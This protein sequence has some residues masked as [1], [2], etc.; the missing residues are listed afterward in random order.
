MVDFGGEFFD[1]PL[2]SY[3]RV[4]GP[5]GPDLRDFP[6][7]SANPL[8]DNYVSLV[9]DL[10]GAGTN[11]TITFRFDG[12][13]DVD[14]LPNAD[15]TIARGAPFFL[16]N[17]DRSSPA[18]GQRVPVIWDFQ[19]LETAYQSSNLLT[20]APLHGVPLRHK[21]TYAAIVTT[22]VAQQN[23]LFSEVWRPDHPDHDTW[24]PVHEALLALGVSVGDV[25]VATVFTTQ[26]PMA[27]MGEWSWWIRNALPIPTWDQSL[28]AAEDNQF[29][30]AAEG[31]LEV[32]LWQ[33][34]DRPYWDEG[35]GFERSDDGTPSIYAWE[36]IAFTLAWPSSG[37]PPADG[38]P[39][40]IY[41][42]GTGGD[43]GTCCDD[44][45]GLEP[46]SMLAKAGFAT[47]GISQPLHGD[48][49]TSDTQVDFHT[50]NYLNPDAALSTFRQGGLDA[51]YQAHALTGRS[52]VFDLGG[53]AI[54]LDP[55]QV[56]FLGHSQGGITGALAAPFL[57]GLVDAVALS[58]AGGGL[59][60]TLVYRE[61][62]GLD[63]EELLRG[64]LALDA[65][66]E[67]DVLHPV[68]GLI[69]LLSEVT[70]PLNYARHWFLEDHLY[71]EG[72]VHVLM[73]EGLND[74]YTPPMT[75]EAMAAAGG[76]PILD[77]IAH[78]DDAH[79]L[80][81]PDSVPLPSGATTTAYN[82]QDITAA[83][84][85][86]PDDGHFAIFDNSDAGRLYRDF[87]KSAREGV[88]VLGD[89]D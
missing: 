63:I 10:D 74:A 60:Y 68:T 33:H 40:V 77:P 58:G 7:P 4:T 78:L 43:H 86:F 20:L 22:R 72:P 59:S 6:N 53:V 42:H 64:V 88:P 48:R 41:S 8:I 14:D 38:W 39:V 19:E 37:D 75:T 17:V 46:A 55:A 12:P 87:L 47:L 11:P 62:G 36:N 28:V 84:A 52:H 82:G 32:P 79:R 31:L 1:A 85:Q 30:Q 5:G 83:L 3:K 26:D 67:L 15:G 45:G 81:L 9:A 69:Q 76:L 29:F 2:P 27:E 57:G 89:S 35:G 13:I 49:A 51:I 71:S 24:Q 21:T 34:G 50:F 66:E 44:S 80:Y 25:A 70:D 73:T 61:Q 65:D 54:P 18:W 56:F 16:I 23:A